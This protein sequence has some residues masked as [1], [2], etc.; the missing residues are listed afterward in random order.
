MSAPYIS[1]GTQKRLQKELKLFKDDPIEWFDTYP[2]ESNNLIWYFMVQGPKDTPYYGGYYIGQ[3]TFPADYPAKGPDYMMLTPSGRFE[4]NKK[5]CL[6]NSG[7]HNESWSPIWNVRTIIIGFVSIMSDDTTTGVAHIK[8]SE[9]ERKR[10]AQESFNYNK[11]YHNNILSGF[12]KFLFYDNNGNMRMK[13]YEEV[14]K[15]LKERLEQEKLEK[16]RKAKK[17]ADKLEK[18]KEKDKQKEIPIAPPK[19]NE[20]KEVEA[21]LKAVKEAEEKEKEKAKAAK[22]AQ[23]LEAALKAVKD[24]EEKEKAAKEAKEVEAALK[25]VKDAEEKEKAVNMEIDED[26][27]DKED[28]ELE[29]DVIME[30]AENK[31]KKRGRKPKVERKK[32]VKS[33]N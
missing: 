7:F 6:T 33:K 15:E 13:T 28:K 20:A 11:Q 31:P 1:E 32:I 24:A 25:A 23:E 10:L 22:E 4:T 9:S 14:E 30:E 8:S 27:E 5:I 3:I 12:N 21:V 17:K 18:E 26:K 2:N 16:E 29:E 19:E